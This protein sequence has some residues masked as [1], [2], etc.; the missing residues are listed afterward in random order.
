[1]KQILT[2]FVLILFL[3]INICL[4]TKWKIQTK[5]DSENDI[6]SYNTFKLSLG[7]YTKAI[8]FASKCDFSEL[9]SLLREAGNYFL[10]AKESEYPISS[11]ENLKDALSYG[12]AISMKEPCEQNEIDEAKQ[13]IY[14]AFNNLKKYQGNIFEMPQEDDIY[15]TDRGFLHPGGLFTDEDFQRI[16]NQL[17]EGNEK[18]KAA[19]DIL[20]NEEYAQPTATT[21]PSE[22]I[23]RGGN[24]GQNYINAAR[25]ASIAFQNALRWKIE[26]NTLCAQH[27]VD[28]LMSWA[29]TT[30]IVT[31]N[32]D[33]AL[34]LGI[35]GYEFAQAGELM[36]DYEGW[37]KEDFQL[38]KNWMINVWYQFCAKFLRVRNGTWQNAG[39]WWQAP[40][41]Y[42]SNWGLCNVLAVISIGVLCDDVFIYNQGM[43]FFKYDQVGTYED[44]R[45]SVP[46]KNDG[47]TDFLGNLVVTT[48]ESDLETGAYG[49]LG[50]MNESGR[51]IGHACMALGLAVDIAKQGWNQGDDLFSYMDHRL[52]A[53]IEFV[54][55]QVELISDLPWTNYLYGTNGIYYTDSRAQ[56]MEAP[57]LEKVFRPY[58]GTIIGHYEGI[59]GIKMPFSEMAYNDMGIDGG[60]KGP[61]SGYYDHL[62]YSVL[63][64]TREGLA[65]NNKR[66]TELKGK[67]KYNGDLQNLIPSLELEK[68][69]GNIKDD[70]IFHNELGGLINTYETNNNV[71]I[72]K[73]SI[74]TLIPTLPEGEED[75]GKWIWNTGETTQNI[76]IKIDKSF[77]YRVTYTNINGIKSELLFSL[78]VQG[79][80]LPT[81]GIQSIYKNETYIGSEEVEVEFG[82]SLKLELSVDDIFGNILWS[83]GDSEFTTIIPTLTSSRKVFAVFTSQCGRQNIF[84]FQ[85]NVIQKEY[86]DN[87]ENDDK[88]NNNIEGEI[89]NTDFKIQ[90]KNN[91]NEWEDTKDYIFSNSESLSLDI[92]IERKKQFY[93]GAKCDFVIPDSYVDNIKLVPLHSDYFEECEITIIFNKEKA[94]Y[95][96]GISN[97]IIL[98]N[99]FANFYLKESPYNIEEINLEFSIFDKDGNSSNDLKIEDFNISPFE[100]EVK[101]SPIQKKI[102]PTISEDKTVIIKINN[103]NKCFVPRIDQYKIEIK[104]ESS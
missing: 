34:A 58:W 44:P 24:S 43:S 80:C 60:A 73:G 87:N 91:E 102:S 68:R 63:L 32:S 104:K 14:T 20:V 42:W 95:K 28:V 74:L 53:G 47:L 78:A 85:L 97:Y 45:T 9:N 15:N 26:G 83:T 54:A 13:N 79:D 51:D 92:N 70:I 3:K 82:S 19:F 35:Y 100:S 66:P 62:G 23:V 93:I 25:G 64:N 4:D 7:Q 71:G 61:T 88:T 76:T 49:K 67:I 39:K 89:Q 5:L 86:I 96:L 65:P 17:K 40:G 72:P 12:N 56:L 99:S 16:K 98:I 18:V 38:F 84:T 75:S 90:R 1:M 11:L 6:Y 29:K 57:A 2:F 10:L 52:A 48:K 31:G 59:K 81:K 94:K 36:R 30:K 103:N 69:M 46:I 55:G 8:I 101:F 41:H 27:A 37:N 33:Q 50:Q 21:Y 22:S 77:A